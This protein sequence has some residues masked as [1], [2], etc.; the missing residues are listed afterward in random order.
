MVRD[1]EGGVPREEGMAGLDV[2]A[3]A[4]VDEE[5]AEKVNEE[6]NEEL[7]EEVDK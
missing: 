7:S 5:A 6:V 3:A 1:V 4:E 2:V